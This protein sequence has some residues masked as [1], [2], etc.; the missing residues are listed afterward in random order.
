MG[1]RWGR[2]GLE[3]AAAVRGQGLG[4]PGGRGSVRADQLQSRA[5]P[6]GGGRG[7]RHGRQPLGGAGAQTWARKD[8]DP[9]PHP[10]ALRTIW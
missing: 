4:Q 5:A 1:W 9:S 8:A 2:A 6:P 3:G 10:R 7:R